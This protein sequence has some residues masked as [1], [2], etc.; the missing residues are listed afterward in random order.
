MVAH[1]HTYAE[2]AKVCGV[3][4]STIT[5]L[6]ATPGGRDYLAHHREL[7]DAHRVLLAATLPYLDLARA[8]ATGRKPSKRDA[9]AVERDGEG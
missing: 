4:K 2:T 9:G 1:G 6:I 3:G 7:V 8:V 5:L